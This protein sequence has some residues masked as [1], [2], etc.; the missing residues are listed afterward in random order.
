MM[1]I[2]FK[3]RLSNIWSSIYEKLKQHWGWAEKSVAYKK[4]VYVTEE[5][6]RMGSIKKNFL[7]ISRNLREK[8]ILESL[9]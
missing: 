3:Q 1:T 9:L 7:K 6:A 2:C 5:A 4:S 8:P